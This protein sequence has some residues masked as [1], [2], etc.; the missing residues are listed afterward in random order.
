MSATRREMLFLLSGLVSSAVE[1]E[2]LPSQGNSLPS[3]TY[4]FSELPMKTVNRGDPPGSERQTGHRRGAG[5]A[6]NHYRRAECRMPRITT[7]TAKS[8]SFGKVGPAHDH[9]HKSCYGAGLGGICSFQR[10]A[11]N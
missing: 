10:R 7:F 6:R 5:S 1:L 4:P 9:P 11:R 2:G 3:T 8:G